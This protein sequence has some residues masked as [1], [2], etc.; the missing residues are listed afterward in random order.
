[1]PGSPKSRRRRQSAVLVP[2]FR[3]GDGELRV[4]MVVRGSR[5]LHGGQLGLPGGRS[6]PQDASPLETALRESEEEIGLPRSEVEVLASLAAIDTR[7]TGFRV[8]PYLARVRP[9]EWRLAPGEISGVVMPLV[10]SLADRSERRQRTLSFPTW[11]ED[12]LVECVPV[13]GGLFL[14]GLTLR[15]LDPVL[16][17]LLAGEW[18]V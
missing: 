17:R 11:T 5:G 3:G 16:P 1:M 6:E 18:D 7:T 15:V 10:R 2:V 13:E 4:I 14:W 9:R 8:H 12:R